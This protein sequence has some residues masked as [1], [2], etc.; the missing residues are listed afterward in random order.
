M[1]NKL[2]WITNVL[3]TKIYKEYSDKYI[4]IT[5]T[6]DDFDINDINIDDIILYKYTTKTYICLGKVISIDGKKI[7]IQ[8]FH[9]LYMSN[10][11]NHSKSKMIELLSELNYLLI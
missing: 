1:S 7:A 3:I 11:R 4:L 2:I 6:N 9:D 10:K 8:K 5:S